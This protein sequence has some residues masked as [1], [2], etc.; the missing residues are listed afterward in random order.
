MPLRA[1]M[2]ALRRLR[3]V[4]GFGQTLDVPVAD[5]ARPLTMG[6]PAPGPGG[7]A[8]I[9]LPARLAQPAR[10]NFRWLSARTGTEE[11]NDLPLSSPICGWVTANYLDEAVAFHGA[12]GTA[13]GEVTTDA[14]QPWRAAP[15]GGIDTPERAADP[16]LGRVARLL[17]RQGTSRRLGL[18]A[19]ISES[20]GT[21]LP[22]INGEAPTLSLVAGRPLAVVRARIGF[23]LRGPFAINQSW[24][25]FARDLARAGDAR[26]DAGL[27][28]VRVPVRL[29]E[30]GRLDDGLVGF[31][32]EDSNGQPVGLFHM[33]AVT[34]KHDGIAGPDDPRFLLNLP[35][36]GPPVTLTMLIDPL[37]DVHATC[38]ILPVKAISVPR[39][40][41]DRTLRTLESWFSAAPLLSPT[42]RLE[43]PLPAIDGRTWAWRERVGDG[44]A[45]L[46]SAA[47]RQPRQDA[48]FDGPAELR[49]GWLILTRDLTR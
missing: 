20:L 42:T 11:A 49:E 7:G 18:L 21:I 31:W 40:Y 46:P 45:G 2:M 47:L 4:D 25:A 27:P 3:I 22:R 36:G 33:P 17:S 9:M 38:G 5:V 44:W 24:S 16:V 8:R 15:G 29:G 10:L 37:G 1:G 26:H 14:S 12:D 39:A 48:A 34:G 13:L 32:R 6:R 28:Q 35:L 23:E 19:A 30:R 41:F 43:V